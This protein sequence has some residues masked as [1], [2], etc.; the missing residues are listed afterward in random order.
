M[1]RL[2]LGLAMTCACAEPESDDD[3]ASGGPLEWDVPRDCPPPPSVTAAPQS[4]E[5]VVDLVNAL[6]KPTSLSCYLQALPRPLELYAT[7]S[8][9][10]AQ[11]A[12]GQGD[13]RIFAFSGPLVQSVVPS[14]QG[15]PLLELSL[16]TSETRS[17]K[18]EIV[19]PVEV[20]LAPTD[21]YDHIRSGSGTGCAVCH[22]EEYPSAQVTSTVAYE[23]EA[24]QPRPELGVSLSLVR[25]YARD[26]DPE[27][28]PER[29][30]ILTGLFAHGDTSPGEFPASA[31]ICL[32][33]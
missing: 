9:F 26:C 13:P 8:A 5:E 20:E 19:F 4:I 1:R 21:P 24:L 23:S 32:G 15:A 14:G 29:C 18:A 11:P 2:A 7:T 30:G 17:I 27:E 16:L 3:G 22:L 10:S 31:K 28:T 25:Q 33:F 12:G 6:P